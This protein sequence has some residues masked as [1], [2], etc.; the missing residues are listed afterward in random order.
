MSKSIPAALQCAQFTG[1][2][3]LNELKGYG[4]FFLLSA[5]FLNLSGL[6]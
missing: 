3:L 2:T 6:F 1:S 5:H 4:R